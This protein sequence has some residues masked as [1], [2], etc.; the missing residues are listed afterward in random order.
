MNLEVVFNGFEWLMAF[1]SLLG[2]FGIIS[3]IFTFIIPEGY[4][5]KDFFVGISFCILLFIIG[6]FLSDFKFFQ[7][8]SSTMTPVRHPGF[9]SFG[10]VGHYTMFS[11]SS[12]Y[13]NL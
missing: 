1:F 8:I 2:G 5:K 7:F 9:L 6:S 12:P 13:L 3:W 10:R 4:D 11:P